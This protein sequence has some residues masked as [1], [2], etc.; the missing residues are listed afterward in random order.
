[1]TT[2]HPTA[3][4]ED[5]ARLG[6]EVTIGPYCTVGP[7]VT[8]GDRVTLRSHVVLTGRTEIGA[9]TAIHPFAVIG[10]E[11]QDLSYKGEETGVTIGENC[12]IREYANVHRGTA[13][14]RQHTVVGPNCFLMV[15][16]HVA[17]DCV[18]GRNVI[19]VNQAT[20]GG[21]ATVGD[22]AVIGGL[23]A[24]QQR[25]R[26]GAYAFIGG[27]TGVTL[28]IIPY[29]TALG[30]RAELAGLN[31][32]GLKRRGV[33]RATIHAMRAA[34]R[35][36]FFGDGSAEERQERIVAEYGSVPQVMTIID[37]VREGNGR[38]LC[39]PREPFS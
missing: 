27:V 22:F 30:E 1:M 4:V 37:F 34:Y 32:I 29:A 6:D 39:Q 9:G 14:G 28:D 8:I 23:S 16:A 13:R 24:V 17:H 12:L 5:G 25:I 35:E 18:V 26:V 11:P 19:L 10:G 33:D 20:L 7:H 21:H 2:I 38:P 15:G 36:L 31:L 3:I